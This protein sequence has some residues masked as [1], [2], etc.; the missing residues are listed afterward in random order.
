MS[1][2]FSA[3]GTIYGA[4]IVS[5]A[6]VEKWGKEFTSHPV[7]TGPFVFDQWV[8][9]SHVTVK[10]NPTY[11][12]NDAAGKS[13]PYVDEVTLALRSRQRHPGGPP[14]SFGEGTLALLHSTVTLLARFR[15]WSTS[16][17]R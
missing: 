8:P 12:E 17:P 14:P 1:A 2:F 10:R 9:G 7:G 15:G 11:W 4:G 16:V 3:I 5:R 13:L 6:A